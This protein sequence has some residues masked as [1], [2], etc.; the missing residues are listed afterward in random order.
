MGWDERFTAA[1][2][3]TK[4]IR[5]LLGVLLSVVAVKLAL[6]VVVFG[7]SVRCWDTMLL[8]GA[9]VFALAVA[10]AL[11]LPRRFERALTELRVHGALP[12][13]VAEAD[14]IKSDLERSGARIVARA[15][16]IV[17]ALCWRVSTSSFLSSSPSGRIRRSPRRRLRGYRLLAFLTLGAPFA[18]SS[19]ALSRPR[20]ELRVARDG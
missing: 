10:L 16:V 7:A 14:K 13:T 20:G 2:T 8:S 9:S 4:G 12:L 11:S 15:A 19:A 18:A 3:G 5:V 6:E 17:G 1:A